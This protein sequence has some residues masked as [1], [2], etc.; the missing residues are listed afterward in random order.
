M[1]DGNKRGKPILFC[2]FDGTICR[3]KYWR[4]LPPELFDKVQ[5]LLFGADMT[6][7]NDWMMGR[8]TAEKANQKVA[9]ALY[10][11]YK[12]VWRL[13]VN[14]CVTMRVSKT[15]LSRISELRSRYS[16]ILLTGNMDSFSRFTVKSLRLDHHFDLVINSYYE[17]RLKTDNFAACAERYGVPITECF[18]ID[19]SLS[20]C[21]SF[22]ALG[23][24][25]FLVTP[26]RDVDYYLALL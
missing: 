24:T 15:M 2:D 5:N 3:D 25:A 10:M 7:V 19:D 1:S 18:V 16:V 26:E 9:L 21:A 17:R 6:F 4:S 11:P 13:F 22:E 23:G 20:V 14:D 12:M 8:H